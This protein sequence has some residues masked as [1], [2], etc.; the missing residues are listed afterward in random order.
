MT[1]WRRDKN[2]YIKRFD[3]FLKELKR[4]DKSIITN[5]YHRITRILNKKYYQIDNESDNSLYVG[6][7]GRGT[8]IDGFSDVDIL[9]KMPSEEKRRFDSYETNGQ[10]NLLQ[11]I[12]KIL[13]TTYSKTD[14]SG[15]GQVVVIDFDDCKFELV[16]V[17][18]NNDGSFLYPD[19]HDGGSWKKTDPKKEI[20]A[21]NELN[22]KSS[23][24][25]K[26]LCK[27]LRPWKN[28]SNVAISGLLLDT[29]VYNFIS[30][31]RNHYAAY[32]L[33][34]YP[35]LCYDFFDY[36]TKLDDT[37]T[38]WHAP[39]SNQ[40]VDNEPGSFYKK[41]E[42]AKKKTKL[43]IERLSLATNNDD[44]REIFGNYFPSYT[45][46]KTYSFCEATTDSVPVRDEE[47]FIEKLF[48]VQLLYSMQIQCT[49]T[50]DGFRPF[51]LKDRIPI[52]KFRSLKF[53]VT[54]NVPRPYSLYWKVK[55][56]GRDAIKRNC[57]RG[58]IER[59]HG[60]EEKIEHSD[61]Q[62][63]HYVEAYIVKNGVCVARAHIDVPIC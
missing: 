38:F 58:L 30:N 29:L 62:G 11:E 15:D 46:C 3:K 34:K 8:A 45:P 14:I 54:H 2:G 5:R 49:V 10:S 42:T 9:F 56:I 59:D 17:F 24:N 43:A 13:K 63:N 37:Q 53:F 39:G 23:G 18:E 6:S 47:Q 22:R 41:A 55:N 57:L 27:M 44:W 36:L 50:R 48:P 1:P 21:F 4:D 33:Q 12:K 25:L 20:E 40:Q 26:S 7:F 16:P 51:L 32:T 19:T 35:N 28:K 61:F 60:K 31:D 52:N